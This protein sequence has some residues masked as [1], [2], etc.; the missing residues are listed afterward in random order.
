MAEQIS[1]PCGIAIP[2]V[3]HDGPVDMSLVKRYVEHAEAMGYHSLWVQERML[4]ESPTLEG[5]R[6]RK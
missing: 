2:Q 1:V 6:K 5:L 3:F 4:G